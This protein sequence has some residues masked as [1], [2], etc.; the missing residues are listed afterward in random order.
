MTTPIAE[1]GEGCSYVHETGRS[2]AVATNGLVL[3]TRAIVEALQ[4][5]LESI[6]GSALIT[7]GYVTGNGRRKSRSALDDERP[8]IRL[9]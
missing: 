4:A 2:A 6:S 1:R 3:E 8:G 7:R 9:E 5:L